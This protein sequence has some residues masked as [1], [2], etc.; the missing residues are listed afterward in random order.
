MSGLV[1]LTPHLIVGLGASAGGIDAFKGF[2]QQV[3]ADSGLTYV[4]ILHLS[5]D[6]AS[7]LSEVLQSSSRIPVTTVTDKV[8]VERD[9]VYVVSPRHSLA[10]QDGYLVQSENTRIEERRAPIDIF[11]RTLAESR[12]A[13]AVAVVLSGSGADGSM[14]LKRVK[15]RGGLCL[16]QDPNEAEYRGMPHQAMATGLVDAVL[17]VTSMPARILAYRDSLAAVRLS[18]E[19]QPRTE[20]DEQ[21]L[22]EIFTLLRVRTGHD[23]ANYKRATILRRIERR[24][25]VRQVPDLSSYAAYLREHG[26]ETAVLLK[27]LLISVTNFFRDPEAFATLETTVIPRLFE[28]KGEQDHVRVW[29]PGCATGEE[30]YAIAMLLLE[31]ASS[32]PES[33]GVQVFATDIDDHAIAVAREGLYTLNDAADVS[34]ER[35]RRFFVK[36][37]ESFRVRKDLRETVLFARHNVIKDPPFSHLDLVSCRNVLIYL[38]RTAQQRVLEVIHFG[39]NAGGFLFLGTSESVEGAADL[40]AA[41]DKD[42]HIYQ[43]RGVAARLRLPLPAPAVVGTIGRPTTMAGGEPQDRERP[44]ASEIHQRLLE[45]YAPPSLVVNE[46]HEIVHLSERAGRYLSFSGGEPSHQLLSVIRPELRLELRTALYQAA[47]LR[48][49]VDVNGLTVALDDRRVRVDMRVKPVLRQDDPARGFFL[50]LFEETPDAAAAP[51]AA[52][53]VRMQPGE[54]IRQL[55]DEVGRLRSQL[56][57]TVEQYETQAEELKASN[58]ELQAINEELRSA[59]EELETSKEELQSLNEELRTV[60]QELKLKIEEQTQASNDVQNLINS[61]DIGTV[62]LD[63][64]GCIK[65][66]TPRAR[67]IF[68]LIP[69]DRGRPLSDIN[70]YLER[71][72]LMADVEHVLDR[73]DRV[74]REVATKNGRWHLMRVGPYRTSDDRI[75]GVVLT[76]VDITEQRQAVD[77]VRQSEER[78]RRALAVDTV[79]VLYFRMDG[80]LSDSNEAFTRMCGLSHED[81]KAGRAVWGTM[82]A[83]ESTPDFDLL[84]NELRQTGRATPH[85]LTFVRPG[86]EQWAALATATII[87]DDEGVMFVIDVTDHQRAV[88]TLRDADRRKNEFLATLAH[89]LRNPLAP[90]ANGLEIL[91][92]L[93]SSNDAATRAREMMERQV[94]HMVRLV[95]DLLEVSRITLGKIDLR[96]EHLDLREVLQQAIESTASAVRGGRHQFSAAITNEPLPVFADAVRLGQVFSNLLNNAAKYTPEGGHIRLVASRRALE[97][98]VSIQDDGVGI[99]EHMLPHVFD[100]F[101]QGNALPPGHAQTGLGIGLTL[102]RALVLAH[103]GHVEA[104]SAGIGRGSEFVVTLPVAAEGGERAQTTRAA[105]V[106]LEGRRMIVVDDNRDAAD[107]LCSLL[108]MCGASVTAAY[109]GEEALQRLDADPP[110][111]M[112]IDIGMPNMDGFELARRIR[113]RRGKARPPVLVAVTGWGQPQDRNAAYAA[114]FDHHLTKP[115]DPALVFRLLKELSETV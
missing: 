102:V 28:H 89:E 59:T 42:A 83:A 43:S 64:A 23:F 36:E 66:F 80:R 18:D 70:T 4:V 26:D 41:V 109:S 87:S 112:F 113:Q 110:T 86:G 77:R 7:Q 67:D 99:G 60:N 2:F 33:P 85:Q 14:G 39:L 47:Q 5:P 20:P 29:V 62:F 51:S 74:E 13:H 52:V 50:V 69:A 84:F 27:D 65:L 96:R 21:A 55:E 1:N 49:S 91:R 35:L 81:V 17:P 115:A 9:H 76:F 57:S 16:V 46:E 3:P 30:A 58:E 79:G 53:P 45:Q 90:I 101:T 32:G 71:V 34:P 8:R 6:H 72:D 22:H 95:E 56:R 19:P 31:H 10:M 24:L 114:G 97:V 82:I 54:P 61:T 63:R 44:L 75:E 11:F 103:G 25:G 108:S 100:M 98:T 73:L 104:R 94:A 106:S 48:T 37:G 105:P 107:S 78:L 92:L 93:P 111:V 12:G 68:S 40:F 38:N 15:E 88:E